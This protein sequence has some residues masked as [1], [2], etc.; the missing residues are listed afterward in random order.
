M[1]VADLLVHLKDAQQ[2]QEFVMEFTLLVF[3]EQSHQESRRDPRRS[4]R[5]AVTLRMM[6]A[7]IRQDSPVGS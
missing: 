6:V 4:V 2:K 1:R 3:S 5:E 7:R